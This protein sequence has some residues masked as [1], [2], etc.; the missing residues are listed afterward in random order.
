VVAAAGS[1]LS[2][3][4]R[5]IDAVAAGSAATRGCHS[6]NGLPDPLCTPGVVKTKEVDNI[7]GR[8]KARQYRPPT[9]YT[10]PL[11]RQQII[12]YGYTDTNPA[13]YEEDHLIPLEL[14]GSGD[15]PRNLW[16]EPRQ[17][18]DSASEK[19]RVENWLHRQVC[20]G[21]MTP[22]EAQEGI[23]TNWGQYLPRT[24]GVTTR[25]TNSNEVRSTDATIWAF[26]H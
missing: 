3:P 5:A 13:S 24:N 16:P 21:A 17:G 25:E 7:C 6:Q 4:Q 20:S 26:G 23:R 9:S 2:W 12:A 18:Q 8:G 22:G 15:D 10:G 1:S 19:D 11:K 14:G